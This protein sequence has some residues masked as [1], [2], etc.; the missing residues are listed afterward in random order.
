MKPICTKCIIVG[1]VHAPQVFLK[2]QVILLSFLSF[3]SKDSPF[4]LIFS[5]LK[6]TNYIIHLGLIINTIFV[7][8]IFNKL[9][10][11]VKF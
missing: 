6:G 3:M 5:V 4:F 2:V 8:F 9:V 7:V 1:V 11:R 10:Y